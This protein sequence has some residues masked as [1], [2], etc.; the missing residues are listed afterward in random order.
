LY[1]LS[2]PSKKLLEVSGEMQLGPDLRPSDNAGGNEYGHDSDQENHGKKVI[3]PE[4]LPGCRKKRR[5][6]D[7]SHEKRQLK[8]GDS[9]KKVTSRKQ[10]IAIG[11]SKARE[12]GEKVP[13]AK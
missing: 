13:P 5:D 11:L 10:A 6:R 1:G 3:R 2:V 8:S 12:A 4:I 9:G 7:E